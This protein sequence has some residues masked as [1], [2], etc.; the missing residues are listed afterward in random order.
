MKSVHGLP[1]ALLRKSGL[2]NPKFQDPN[3]KFQEV[4]LGIWFL[5]FSR[6]RGRD[7]PRF[8]PFCRGFAWRPFISESVAKWQRQS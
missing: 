6:M 1:E 3:P 7:S 5:E 8:V 4:G 2:T